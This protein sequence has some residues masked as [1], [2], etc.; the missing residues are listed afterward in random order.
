MFGQAVVRIMPAFQATGADHARRAAAFAKAILRQVAGAATGSG[1][2]RRAA[3]PDGWAAAR[4]RRASRR[5]GRAALWSVATLAGAAATLT[6]LIDAP[7]SAPPEEPRLA[8]VDISKPFALYDVNLPALQPLE[9]A[10]EAR[11]HAEGG[12]RRDR[13]AFGRLG[14]TPY[15]RFEVY[16]HGAEAAPRA[17]LAVAA[18]RRAADIGYGLARTGPPVGLDTRFGLVEVADVT[19]ERQSAR[20]H[21]LAFQSAVQDGVM[22]MSGLS[23]DA[24]GVAPSRQALICQIDQ[25]QL[26]AAGEDEALRAVFVAAD[27]KP[28]ASCGPNRLAG[29]EPA[30]RAAL[31]AQNRAPKLRGPATETARALAA[32]SA[33]KQAM[34]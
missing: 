21:C 5:V 6:A 27:Q 32:Q 18:A 26:M 17:S 13:L 19:I 3:S 9:R 14:D 16:R 34:R 8:W 22:S 10:Y 11:R 1:K 23:C 24:G 2:A 12:G 7:V 30:T 25:I 33:S 28:G 20:Q 4:A 15:L 31:A 29:V